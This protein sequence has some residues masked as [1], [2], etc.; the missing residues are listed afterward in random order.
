ME[1]LEGRATALEHDRRVVGRP[2]AGREPAAVHV[3]R[4]DLDGRRVELRH[5]AP[6]PLNE[7]DEV[8]AVCG[9]RRAPP[10]VYAWHN[11][12][13]GA[14]LVEP[15]GAVAAMR[16][17]LPAVAAIALLATAA[18]SAGGIVGTAIA[19]L[20]TLAGAGFALLALRGFAEYCRYRRAA[21]R[22]DA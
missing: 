12:T 20:M 11:R 15:P 14:T 4:F 13:W 7:G 8:V 21:R 10:R 9:G 16:G 17:W 22:L 2:R 6:L 19:A 18:M 3:Y 5:G 1:R